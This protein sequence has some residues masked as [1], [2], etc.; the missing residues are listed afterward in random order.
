ML[1]P[2]KAFREQFERIRDDAKYTGGG[3]SVLLLVAPEV[4]ALC[5]AR[6]FVVSGA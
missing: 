1:I 2:H 4:D 6:I 5:A 3:C